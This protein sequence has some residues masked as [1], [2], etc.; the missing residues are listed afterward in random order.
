MRLIL[1]VVLQL[2]AIDPFRPIDTG[3]VCYIKHSKP[4][5]AAMATLTDAPHGWASPR[6]SD[7]ASAL[8]CQILGVHPGVFSGMAL[9]SVALAA[10]FIST[11]ADAQQRIGQSA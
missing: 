6:V 10:T 3:A 4:R 9:A 2:F 1:R 5:R 11:Q 8:S 7:L